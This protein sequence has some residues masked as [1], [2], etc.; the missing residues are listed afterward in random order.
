MPTDAAC[1]LP[2]AGSHL[3]LEVTAG[4]QIPDERRETL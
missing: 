1:P 3:G 4:E 2:P